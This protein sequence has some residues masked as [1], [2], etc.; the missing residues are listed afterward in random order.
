[1][2][3][4]NA[5]IG[6]RVICK[7]LP[8]TVLGYALADSEGETG[9]IVALGI[10]AIGRAFNVEDVIVR[11][12]RCFNKELWEDEETNGLVGEFHWYTPVKYLKLEEKSK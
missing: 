1:M 10:D 9:T 12:D 8:D 11:F 2:K 3:M 6:T 7:G 4:K 5:V